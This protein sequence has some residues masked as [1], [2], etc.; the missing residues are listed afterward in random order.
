MILVRRL[1][2]IS[3]VILTSSA[4]KKSGPVDESTR[5]EKKVRTSIVSDRT[6]FESSSY[7][8]VRLGFQLGE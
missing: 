1:A 8:F 2:K 4:G 6:N 5:L 7:I 3:A